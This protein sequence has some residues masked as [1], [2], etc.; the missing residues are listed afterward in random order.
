MARPTDAS[1]DEA[2]MQRALELARRGEGLTRPN[3]PVGAVVVRGDR[4]VGEG[5]HARAGGP[6]AEVVALRRAGARAVGAT[7]YVTL[8]PC[9]TWGR[10]PP[11]TDAIVRSGVARVVAATRDP[12][13][14]HAGRGL[15]WLRRRGLRVAEGLCEKEARELIR[16]FEKWIRLRRPYLTLKMGMSLDGKIADYMGASRW[17]TGPQARRAVHALRR[18]VD[19]VL[20]GTRTLL[21][22]DPSLLPVPARGRKPWRII[23]APCGEVPDQASVLSDRY[24]DRTWVVV[25]TKCPEAA[26]RRLERRGVRVTRVRATQDGLSVTALA[27]QLG[28]MG[29]LHVLCEGGGELAASLIRAGLLDEYLFVV[30]PCIL[31]GRTAPSVV[32]G[33]GWKLHAQPR[34]RFVSCERCGR[35]L[36]IRARPEK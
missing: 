1:L 4:R 8:E 19:G 9:S 34:L 14:A 21:R 11:C 28:R 27:E 18:R 20:V 12:N 33:P 3:P 29:L 6:H 7:L 24:R 32:G 36:M 17:I 5:Y 30:A 26:V 10:T 2:W 35:D 16:P 23:L 25:S 13:P 15:R 31:G 22:D